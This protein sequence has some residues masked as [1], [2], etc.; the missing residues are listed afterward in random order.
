MVNLVR[1][2]LC[3][4]LAKRSSLCGEHSTIIRR[5]QICTRVQHNASFLSEYLTKLMGYNFLTIFNTH[6]ILTVM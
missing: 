5:T 3:M 2:Y 6:N 4:L 1:A